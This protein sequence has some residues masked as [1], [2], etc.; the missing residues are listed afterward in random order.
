MNRFKSVEV[1]K[2][3]V[4][5]YIPKSAGKIMNFSQFKMGSETKYVGKYNEFNFHTKE[6]KHKEVQISEI[7]EKPSKMESEYMKSCQSSFH[8]ISYSL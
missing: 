5:E 8:K 4:A 2:E 1:T 6:P 7:S 3:Q